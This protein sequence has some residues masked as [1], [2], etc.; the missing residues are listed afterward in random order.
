M[1]EGRAEISRVLENGREVLLH[2]GGP[3]VWFADWSVMSG[4]P[5]LCTTA[6]VTH[7]RALVLPLAAFRKLVDAGPRW[8]EE[9]D[10]C[11]LA[12]METLLRAFAAQ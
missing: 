8:H 6:A 4:Q 1:L 12:N 5:T 7:C 11:L 9:F 2:V 10:R 3:G